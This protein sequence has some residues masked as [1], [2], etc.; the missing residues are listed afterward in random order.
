MSYNF[1]GI[2][3][4]T[5]KKQYDIYVKFQSLNY[6]RLKDI[7]PVDSEIMFVPNASIIPHQCLRERVQYLREIVGERE[8]ERNRGLFIRRDDSIERRIHNWDEVKLALEGMDVKIIN[9]SRRTVEENLQSFQN[10]EFIIGVH[11]AGLTDV[12]FCGDPKLIEIVGKRYNQAYENIV[13]VLQGEYH[14][15]KCEQVDTDIKVD[16]GKLE[17]TVKSLK[18]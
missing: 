4:I 3:I 9:P 11:G 15:L 13:S 8:G 14:K 12:I 5:N 1:E 2:D 16:V 18:I 7:V 17:E 6:V 10:A